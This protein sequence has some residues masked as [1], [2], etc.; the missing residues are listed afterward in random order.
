MIS[1]AASNR[2]PLVGEFELTAR[3]NLRCRM[4]YLSR[5]DYDANA[6]EKEHTAKEWIKIAQ[7]AC[8]AGMLY[9]LLTGGEVFLRKD[10]REIYTEV[11]RM[12]L[13]TDIYTNATL[14]TQE[15][16]KWLGQI[17]P[18]KIEVTLYGA[19]PETYA[20]VCGSADAFHHAVRG[21]KLLLAE[22]INLEL[23][24]TVIKSN[25][26]DFDAMAE[27]A[28]KHGVHLGVVN[29]ISPRRDGC[30]ADAD[31]NRLS[32]FDLVQ[33]EDHV[34]RYFEKKHEGLLKKSLQQTDLIK[35]EIASTREEDNL[36]LADN[37]SFRCSSGKYSFWVTWNGQMTPCPLSESTSIWPARHGFRA[38]WEELQKYCSSV[39]VC[40][41]CGKCSLKE[42]CMSCPVRLKNETDSYEKPA[43]YLCKTALLR[44]N[45]AEA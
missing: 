21:I 10:F 28:E 36:S 14:I 25:A 20:K 16:V 37:T 2:I 29:Y 6:L 24:T 39:P 4:C 9:L 45:L 7:D 30:C 42:Y 32:P 1:Y 8:D 15:T 23:R 3:C 40:K 35:N 43:P 11:A 33:Y 31:E 26:G 17:P 34:N 13:R 19:S 22:G 44:K 38:A 5:S 41:E 12:G 27:F 18:S